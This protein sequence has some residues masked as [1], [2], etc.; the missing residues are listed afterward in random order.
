VKQPL[1]P[2]SKQPQRDDSGAFACKFDLGTEAH[3]TW[4]WVKI[5]NTGIADHDK[6]AESFFDESTRKR[7]VT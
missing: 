7:Y 1:A 2:S 5:Y 4:S 6:A 3:R